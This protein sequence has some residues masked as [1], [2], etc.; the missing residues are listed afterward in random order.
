MKLTKFEELEAIVQRLG[1][2]ISKETE[3]KIDALQKEGVDLESLDSLVVSP[4]GIYATLPDGTFFK[5]VLYISYRDRSLIENPKV[6][7]PKF[8]MFRCKTIEQMFSEGRGHK[9]KISQRVDGKFNLY[10]G[11]SLEIALL[12][13]CMHCVNLFNRQAGNNR[14]PYGS[15]SHE[16][17]NALEMTNRISSDLVASE[18]EYDYDTIPNVYSKDWRSIARKF[19]EMKNYQCEKCN[20]KS[21]NF[22]DRKYIHAHHINW[23]KNDNR[24]SNIKI[25]CIECHAKQP[26]HQ[27]I[28]NSADYKEH[29]RLTKRYA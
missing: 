20:W 6:G 11:K 15:S 29:E 2:I 9:Y 27:H 17:L 26:G 24:I 25:L 5:V 21:T 8:H 19:K 28:R 23:M 3:V 7:Y 16:F 14:I 1:V 10:V 4:T 12:E 22:N 13:P 18:F